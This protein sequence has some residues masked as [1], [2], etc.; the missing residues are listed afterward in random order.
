MADLIL[1]KG[2]VIPQFDPRRFDK[3]KS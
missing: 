1:G 2:Q 3:E